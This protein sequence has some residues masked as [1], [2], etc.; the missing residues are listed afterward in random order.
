[1]GGETRERLKAYPS[2]PS[3]TTTWGEVQTLLPW[4][5]TTFGFYATP[6]SQSWRESTETLA[7][8]GLSHIPEAPQ[9]SAQNGRRFYT[10]Y[11]H[12]WP[13]CVR[14]KLLQVP[15]LS[16]HGIL[17]ARILEWVAMPLSSRSSRPR[18]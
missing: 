4:G 11:L 10:Q 7:F 1:M 8:C 9:I 6:V 3:I 17:Q 13:V 16:V 2:P 15:G 5:T 18:D 12:A 14:A